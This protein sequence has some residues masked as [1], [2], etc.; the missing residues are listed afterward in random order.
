[1]STRIIRAQE[2]KQRA[3]RASG[4]RSSIKNTRMLSCKEKRKMQ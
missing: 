1:M 3:G 4:A 2:K